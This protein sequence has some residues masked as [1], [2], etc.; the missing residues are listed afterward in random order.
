MRSLLNRFCR[1]DDG[2]TSIEYSMIAAF[3]AIAIIYVLI[4]ISV[5][6]KSIFVD[7]QAGLQKRPAA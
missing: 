5:E 4:G 7:V 3:I 1:S 6:L 2:A